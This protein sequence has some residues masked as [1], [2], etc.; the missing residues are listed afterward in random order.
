MSMA[1]SLQGT[2]HYVSYLPLTPLLQT[3]WWGNLRGGRGEGL[4]WPDGHF[5]TQKLC[6]MARPP[7]EAMQPLGGEFP[8]CLS[9]HW[10]PATLPLTTVVRRRPRL[11]ASV[12]LGTVE[13]VLSGQGDFRANWNGHLQN[14]THCTEWHL[15]LLALST[16]EWLASVPLRRWIN[17]RDA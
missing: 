15:Q 2:E 1:P 11:Q 16:D 12:K 9:C 4:R 14:Y 17:F 7:P 5:P 10:Y 13:G 3:P 6:R 8:R